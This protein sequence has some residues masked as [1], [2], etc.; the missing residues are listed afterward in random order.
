MEIIATSVQLVIGA[1]LDW[2]TNVQIKAIHHKVRSP[3]ARV[4]VSLDI[5]LPTRYW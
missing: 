5:L 1:S 4:C 3:R 2:Q